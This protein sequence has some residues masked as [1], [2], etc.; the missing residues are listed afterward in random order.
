MNRKSFYYHFKDKLDLIYWIYLTEV[1]AITFGKTYANIWDFLEDICGI[2]WKDRKF[3]RQVFQIKGQNSL[4]EGMA[5]MLKPA[6][7][8]AGTLADEFCVEFLADSLICAIE[9]WICGKDPTNPV[10]FVAKIKDCVV[11]AKKFV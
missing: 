1:N 7:K 3:Y 11:Q 5:E 2:V 10:D 6:L 8:N 4:C 9:K